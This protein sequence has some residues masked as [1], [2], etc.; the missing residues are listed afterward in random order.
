ML[1]LLLSVIEYGS[2]VSIIKFLVFIVSFFLWISLA[3]WLN[4]DV[5][6]VGE[7]EFLWKTVVTA[8]GILATIIWLLVPVFIVGFIL[9]LLAVGITAIIYVKYRNSRV[10]EYDRILNIDHIKSLL[11][12]KGQKKM[13]EL[14]RF[15]FITANKNE[16]SMP[17]P[18]TAEFFGYRAAYD[19]FNDALWRRASVIVFSPTSQGYALSYE[20]DGAILKQPAISKEQMDYFIPFIKNLADLDVK[21]RRKPQKGKFSIR[22]ESD[23]VKWEVSTAGSTA[24]EQLQVKLITQEDVSRLSDIGL[25]KNQYDQMNQIRD[26]KEGVFI[27]SGPKKSGVTTSFYAMI[28]NHDS[29]LN[30]INTL[31]RKPSGELDNV[32]QD[33]YS[34]SDTG[35]MSYANKLRFIVRMGPDIVGADECLDKETANIIC[36]AA[37]DGKIIYVNIE[38]DNAIRAFAKWINLVGDRKLAIDVLLGISNQRLLRNLCNECKQAY[39][40]NKE[41]LKKFSLPTEKTKALYR[42][43]KVIYDKHGKESTCEN[44]QGTGFVGRTGVFEIITLDDQLKKNISQLTSLAEISAQFRAAK[45]LYLQQQALRKIITGVTSVNEMI[46][47]LSKPENK[48][49]KK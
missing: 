48:K 15:L 24:G 49:P 31:E 40:P 19:L 25:T 10:L 14:K 39:T 34:L 23:D 42:P 1:D 37:K 32:T 45:M 35:T 30:S 38:A 17:G 28:R 11:S 8:T 20:V 13:D 41:L 47:V 46:R 44:C 43:G 22:R 9:Y 7:N 29:F 12:A 21:E 4:E 2:Y 3:V 36:E 26:A 33:V 5:A 16:I 18:K 27:I 6:I